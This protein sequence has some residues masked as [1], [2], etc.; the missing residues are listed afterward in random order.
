MEI[1]ITI[2]V[3]TEEYA[4]I[5][6]NTMRYHRENPV[7]IL[8]HTLVSDDQNKISFYNQSYLNYSSKHFRAMEQ[9]SL[10]RISINLKIYF[11][12]ESTLEYNIDYAQETF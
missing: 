4:V 6:Y 9:I 1:I 7:L 2:S 11:Y 5:I 8:Y 3:S 10:L 12:K